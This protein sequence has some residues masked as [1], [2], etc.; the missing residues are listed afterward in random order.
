MYAA[1]ESSG[2]LD[3]KRRRGVGG[4]PVALQAA[5]GLAVGLALAF[6]LYHIVSLPQE[7]LTTEGR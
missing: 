7:L 6:L 4:V 2:L 3:A 5:M 1:D